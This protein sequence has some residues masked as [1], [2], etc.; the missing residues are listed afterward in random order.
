MSSTDLNELN[1][2]RINAETSQADGAN[3]AAGCLG[4]KDEE[5]KCG[6]GPMTVRYLCGKQKYLAP[7]IEG[8][9]GLRLSDLNHYSRMEN[10][11]M[12]NNEMEKIFTLDRTNRHSR[13]SYES[14]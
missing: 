7:V 12:R 8:K 11:K 3:A 4:G 1:S 5:L 2:K 14:G 9:K 6:D 10:D 13:A